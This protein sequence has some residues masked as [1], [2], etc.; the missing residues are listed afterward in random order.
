MIEYAAEEECEERIGENRIDFKRISKCMKLL[1]VDSMKRV[2]HHH[3]SMCVVCC[4]LLAYCPL[5]RS[6][7]LI[8]SQLK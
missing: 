1:I 7:I 4:S 5:S 2:D 6:Y 8:L 3:Y